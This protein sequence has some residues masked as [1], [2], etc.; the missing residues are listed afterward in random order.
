VP[1]HAAAAMVEQ[2]QAIEAKLKAS[3]TFPSFGDLMKFKIVSTLFPTSDMRHKVVTPAYLLLGS[4]LSQC[5]VANANDVISGLF[6]VSMCIDYATA[7]ERYLPE[8]LVFL[9]GLLLLACGDGADSTDDRCAPG[10]RALMKASPRL[11]RKAGS[12]AGSRKATTL[13]PLKMMFLPETDAS[14]PPVGWQVS[15]VGLVLGQA[16]SLAKVYKSHKSQA[17][18]FAPLRSA[19]ERMALKAK[20]PLADAAAEFAEASSHSGNPL[21]PLTLQTHKPVPLNLIEPDFKDI[22]TARKGE[23]LEK[24]D[25]EL[26]KLKALHKKEMRGAIREI[27]KDAKFIANVRQKERDD[28]DAERNVTVAKYENQ[29]AQDQGAYNTAERLEEK[30]KGKLR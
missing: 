1:K 21:W 30:R 12:S 10:L 25:R 3:W 4:M 28:F 11:L 29:L 13:K 24:E 6:V 5:T 17:A 7:A 2:L 15:V 27:R 8:V 19:V 9:H 16:T 18:I 14:A 22:F 26:R 20:S 23:G